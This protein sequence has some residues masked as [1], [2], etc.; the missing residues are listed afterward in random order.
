[1]PTT[2]VNA[3]F[4]GVTP[5]QNIGFTNSWSSSKR[6]DRYSAYEDD[7][8][9][10]LVFNGSFT[11]TDWRIRSM[12]ID[13][14]SRDIPGASASQTVT[15]TDMDA[16][17]G[18]RIESL[19]VGD[20]SNIT[21]QSTRIDWLRGFNG[22]S[23]SIDI[24]G[25]RV[26]FLEFSGNL[27]TIS[28]GQN[29]V[30]Y[31]QTNHNGRTN[32]TVQS[33]GVEAVNL[34]NGNDTVTV[35]GGVTSLRTNDG[36][37]RVQ[38]NS[39]GNIASFQGGNGNDRLIIQGRAGDSF[40]SD[41]NDSV[42]MDGGRA[43]TIAMGRGNDTVRLLNGS[44]I[45]SLLSG[46][47]DALVVL[48]GASRINQ[49]TDWSG[50]NLTLNMSGDSRISQANFNGNATINLQDSSRIFQAKI[51]SGT[52]NITTGT[53]FAESFTGFQAS[54]NATFGTGGLGQL[55]TFSDV[56]LNHVITT[57][58]Y[59][60]SIL[61]DDRF[62]DSSDDNGTNLTV[63]GFAESINL[64]NGANVVTVGQNGAIGNYDGGRGTDRIVATNGRV[65][66]VETGEG[67]DTVIT[68]NEGAN[69][70]N[71]G[72]QNDRI[73]IGSG[74]ATAVDG[75]N[76]NDF[77]RTGSG[78][79]DLIRGGSGKDTIEVG[80]G[81]A[82]RVSAGDQNDLIRVTEMSATNG[83]AVSGGRGTDTMVFTGFTNGIFFDLSL[84]GQFQNVGAAG[85]DFTVPGVVGYFSE[86]SIENLTG[87][88]Q[89]DELRGD[90]NAN[91]LLG[92]GGRDMIV[93]S[94]GDDTL[95]GGSGNDTLV[96]NEDNDS[97]NG[98]SGA[99]TLNGG[100]GNDTLIGGGGND[101]IIGGGGNDSIN[102]GNG[103]DVFVFGAGAG[104]DSIRAF[105]DGT[106]IMEIRGHTGGFATLQITN[107]AGN[108]KIVH[109]GGTILLLGDAGLGL[110]D[111]DFDFV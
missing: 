102:G 18:R 34:A 100:S 65:N 89:G 51:D 46:N 91:K 104:V 79:L 33:G 29:Y 85:G 39:N 56:A 59:V 31:I 80:S 70:I 68:G 49:L 10:D 30:K 38:I 110:M 71:T 17:T 54:L 61:I 26:D 43:N 22:E 19:A 66:E 41:G 35:D 15:L 96:G 69:L 3:T 60:G 55:R 93:G 23:H 73:I 25:G 1:M 9:N 42:R 48:S 81:G 52:Y 40:L 12:S 90:G 57:N 13:S 47:D 5:V 84:G 62:N 20:N 16:G 101:R 28:T 2:T 4:D 97:L 21:L 45:N 75:G 63:N 108:R 36:N 11:G 109:D 7:A 87:T 103:A 50:G 99:D 67:K 105:Q 58:G 78:G 111:A 8:N 83:V 95:V 53:S 77:I 14:A 107:E 6:I 74:G 24:G 82:G 88:G 32:L 44:E 106:D 86:V 64:G 92:L 94:A 27:N 98:G 37:D 76:G 72:D